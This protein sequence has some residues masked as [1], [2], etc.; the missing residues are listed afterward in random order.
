M[1]PPTWPY[2]ISDP[3]MPTPGQEEIC[4]S[5]MERMRNKWVHKILKYRNQTHVVGCLMMEHG[6]GMDDMSKYTSY[7]NHSKLMLEK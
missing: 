1:P 2:I 5:F 7:Q 6:L 4:R 3:P